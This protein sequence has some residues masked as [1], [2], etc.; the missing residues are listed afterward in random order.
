MW[1]IRIRQ[2]K[3]QINPLLSWSY[4]LVG[5]DRRPNRTQIQ[6]MSYR[7]MGSE[8]ITKARQGDGE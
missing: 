4:S 6:N 7:D 3:K 1:T 2:G 5:K 8:K